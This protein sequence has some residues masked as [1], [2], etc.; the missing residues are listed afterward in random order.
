MQQQGKIELT[1]EE[2]DEMIQKEQAKWE[3]AQRYARRMKEKEEQKEDEVAVRNNRKKV[4][5]VRLGK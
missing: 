3:R 5:W 2:M 4:K 1:Q